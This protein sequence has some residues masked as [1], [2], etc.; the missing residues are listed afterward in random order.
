MCVCVFSGSH[1]FFTAQMQRATFYLLFILLPRHEYETPPRTNFK[2][3]PE[4]FVKDN[5][6]QTLQD[7]ELTINAFS[8]PVSKEYTGNPYSVYIFKLHP[9]TVSFNISSDS[10]S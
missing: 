1:F 10:R 5:N 7:T 8:H 6:P 2:N 3:W 9:I 4:E